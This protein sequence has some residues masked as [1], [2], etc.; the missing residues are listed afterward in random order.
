MQIKIKYL[1]KRVLMVLAL[2]TALGLSPISGHQAS[3][4]SSVIRITPDGLLTPDCGSS[5]ATACDLQYAINILADTSGGLSWELWVKAG[6][7]LPTTNSTAPSVSFVLKNGVAFYGGFEGNEAARDERSWTGHSSILS[8]DIGHDDQASPATDTS[9]IVGVNAYHVVTA[10]G[11]NQTAILD[12]FTVTAGKTWLGGDPSYREGGGMQIMG[13]SPTLSNLIFSGNQ[14]F[15]SSGGGIFNQPGD[16]ILTNVDFIGNGGG[17]Q[18]G[19]GFYND[20]GNPILT[21]ITFINNSASNG[22]GMSTF[23]N[24]V[25]T[26]VTFKDNSSAQGGGLYTGGNA[27]LNDITFTGN[28]AFLKGGGITNY[29]ILSI[30]NGIF[31][32]NS[33][34][35]G[36]G[37]AIYNSNASSPLTIS[38]VTFWGNQAMSGGGLYNEF[39]QFVTLNN[40]TLTQNS[41]DS[42]GG[43]IYSTSFPPVIRNGILWNNTPDQISGGVS[44]SYSDIQSVPGELY[45]GL[46]NINADPLFGPVGTYG[47]DT[48]VFPLLPGSPAIDAGEN[49]TCAP[50][51]Q[52]GVT[53]LQPQS[54]GICDMGAYETRGYTLSISGNGNNQHVDLGAPFS[55]P[56]IVTISS[57]YSEP[58][59]GGI[60]SFSAPNSGASAVISGSP[61]VVVEGGTATVTA[62]A[63]DQAGTYSVKASARGVAPINFNIT[64]EGTATITSAN[65]TVNPSD[66]GQSVT[67]DAS[68][69]VLPPG[70]GEPTGTVI[71]YHDDEE[72]GSAV[73]DQG[74]AFFTTSGLPAGTNDITAAYMGNGPFSPSRSDVLS[75]VVHPAPVT[76]ELSDLNFTYDGLA[77]SATVTTHPTGVIV[78]ILYNGLSTFPVGSG[79]YAVSASSDDPNYFG[80]AT[81]TLAIE[82]APLTVT[83]ANHNRVYGES[84]PNFTYIATGFVHSETRTIL[85]GEPVLTTGATQS[86]TVGEY[87]ISIHPGT[88]T[89]DNY[90][91]TFVPGT[92]KID[93]ASTALLVISSLPTSISGRE[94]TFTAV[95]LV[96]APGTGMPTGTV[97]FYDGSTVIGST[98]LNSGQT[99][100]KISSLAVGT[101]AIKAV[102][103]GDSNYQNSISVEIPLQVDSIKWYLPIAI[104]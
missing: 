39:S 38:G 7:Y 17:A 2:F 97:T 59:V 36:Y 27:V 61:A 86:S 52:R 70:T 26:H 64:N 54:N 79:S 102:Y 100:L 78:N 69:A 45:P 30:T 46:G 80:S 50:T 65:S 10:N 75:Q 58:V 24:A 15:Q 99:S 62:T 33:V 43:G 98:S 37:G 72:L 6:T 51:D 40:V 94:V 101:H 47:G 14:A 60:I 34:T 8:G 21:D 90:H 23:G 11:V 44:V 91:L 71:F 83:A 41:A 13:G 29:G 18:S 28:I 92:L 12:G 95:A 32:G 22:G 103:G 77:H 4:A 16:P 5:W 88:L 85:Q 3:A 93:K 49:A 96:Q 9:K 63:N 57:A 87:S 68:V 20:G 84:N 48:Q 35:N 1:F 25:L 82:Q 19:G 67:I 81:G 31:E 56:L 89:A 42:M 53:R 55:Y 66:Y 76:I 74:Q 104:R 73:L